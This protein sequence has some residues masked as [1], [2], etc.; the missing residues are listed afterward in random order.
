MI[1]TPKYSFK[2][3]FSPDKHI[4][5]NA[6]SKS[7]VKPYQLEMTY[8]FLLA[9][10]DLKTPQNLGFL[11]RPSE[12]QTTYLEMTNRRINEISTLLG[13]VYYLF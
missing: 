1:N 5:N 9:N 13:D 6:R 10:M 12:L 7:E 8:R 3:R 2:H 11:E 4:I